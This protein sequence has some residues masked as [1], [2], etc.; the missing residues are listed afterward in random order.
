MAILVHEE[1][2]HH[3]VNIQRINARIIQVT[4]H[5]KNSHTPLTILCTYAP[6][7]G[8]TKIQQKEHWGEVENTIEAFPNRHMLIWCTDANGQPDRDKEA[9][10]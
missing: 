9:E 6:H 5:S 7:S 10:K 2:E 4:L 1:L 3:I 8:K